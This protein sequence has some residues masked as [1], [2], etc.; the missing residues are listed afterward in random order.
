[1]LKTVRLQGYID[2]DYFPKVKGYIQNERLNLAFT[3][4]EHVRSLELLADT[5][6]SGSLVL[7][8]KAM[9]SIKE[10]TLVRMK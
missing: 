4:P 8:T 9:Q 3:I 7:D 1:M 10:I 2:Q 5:G 6:F